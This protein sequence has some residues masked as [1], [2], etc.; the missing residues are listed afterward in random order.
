MSIEQFHDQL[1][2]LIDSNSAGWE[3][4]RM[5]R[6]RA[7]ELARDNEHAFARGVEQGKRAAN[8]ALRR[9]DEHAAAE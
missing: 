7:E 8:Q 2:Q 3:A 1:G 4:A 5:W 9:T 6:E